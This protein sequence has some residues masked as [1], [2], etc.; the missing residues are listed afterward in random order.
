MT[1]WYIDPGAGTDSNASAGN[2]DSVGTARKKLDNI[3][4]AALAPGDNIK[5]LK[6]PAPVSLGINATWESRPPKANINISS[7]TNATPIVVTTSTSHG[8]SAG[9]TVIVDNHA[10]NTK[11]NGVWKVG[12]PTS[13][14][15]QL[16][17]EDGT[18]STG[19][20]SGSSGTVTDISMSNV[21]LASALTKAVL[22]DVR[23]SRNSLLAERIR[24][25]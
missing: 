23:D 18:N 11:A 5:Y 22:N 13:T 17:H 24:R 21:R 2:G 14:T 10:T 1:T 19:N 6:S 16:L 8:L 15:F 4:A 25:V 7:S 12:S 20:G 3:V 9:D